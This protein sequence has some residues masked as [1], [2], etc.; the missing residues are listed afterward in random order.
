MDYAQQIGLSVVEIELQETDWGFYDH[1]GSRIIL[2]R[3]LTQSQK[4]VTLLHEIQ[5]H[6]RGDK[7]PQPEHIE[8]QIDEEVALMLIKPIDYALA[9]TISEHPGQIAQELDLPVHIIMAWQR[10]ADKHRKLIYDLV[11]PS[12]LKL[13][14]L[15]ICPEQQK[16][17]A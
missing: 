3:G 8:K 14:P 4:L 5:H 15:T 9:E 16:R 17:L 13:H 7:T 2:N 6:E 1:T 10:I 11:A 12:G